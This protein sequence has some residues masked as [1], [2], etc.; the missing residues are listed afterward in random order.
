VRRARALAQAGE[1]AYGDEHH[2]QSR[3][4]AFRR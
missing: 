1:Q 4:G 2:R 3:R